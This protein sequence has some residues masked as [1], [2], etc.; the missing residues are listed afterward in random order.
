[1]QGIK[2]NYIAIN[3][4]H[5]QLDKNV[6][7]LEDTFQ[8]MISILST[9]IKS[10][11]HINHEL[12]ELKTGIIDLVNGKLSPLILPKTVLDSTLTDIQNILIMM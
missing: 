12:D 9:Q 2:D 10:A 4:I 6:K 3:Y 5:S 7:T 1:M 11:T 8:Q